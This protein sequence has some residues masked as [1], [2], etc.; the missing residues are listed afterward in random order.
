MNNFWAV[1]RF[2]VVDQVRQKSFM[3]L[4]GVAILLVMMIRSCFGGTYSVNGQS[5]DSLTIAWNASKIAFHVIT[6]FMYLLAVLLSMKIISRD[7]DDGS[8]VMFLSRPLHRWQY[9]GG[10]VIGT[11]IISSVF[12]FLL[13]LTI[14]CIMWAK[15]GG[16]IPGYLTASFLCSVNLLFVITTVCLLSLALPDIIS[17]VATLGIVA[18]GFASDGGFQLM[19]NDMV[20]QALSG[21]NT[22][23]ALWRILYPKLFLVQS[24]AG[25][26]ITKTDFV[27]L[28]PVHPLI[29][30]V[31]WTIP[32]GALLLYGFQRRE[33]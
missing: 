24:Y 30:V 3:V 10:R 17:A 16:R 27:N 32:L 31:L 13:H 1:T 12:M 25:S 9:M 2:T 4:L 15:T 28:G 22:S 20:R 21:V 11:W 33:I 19:N 8:M 23:P 7:Q 26:L 14:F 18:V 29:N 6:F 5:V